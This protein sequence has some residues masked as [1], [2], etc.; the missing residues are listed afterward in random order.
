[1][2]IDEFTPIPKKNK[3]TGIKKIKLNL[4]AQCISYL[5]D[6]E[7]VCVAYKVSKLFWKALAK[8]F[9]WETLVLSQE[10]FAQ[11]ETKCTW[12]EYYFNL[13]KLSK[14]YKEGRPNISFKML[15]CRGHKAPITVLT[16]I[17]FYTEY[18]NVE[19]EIEYNE[20]SKKE[21][22]IT[23]DSDGVIYE[24]FYNKEEKEYQFNQ[25]NKLDK[26][27]KFIKNLRIPKSGQELLIAVGLNGQTKVFDILNNFIVVSKFEPSFTLIQHIA[28]TR[29]FTVLISPQTLS[30]S[31]L[32]KNCMLEEFDILSG[33]LVRQHIPECRYIY[34]NCHRHLRYNK[35][36]C[37]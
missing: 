33:K 15:P 25:I 23:G 20:L 18:N 35:I 17:A 31:H 8:D 13:K 19:D 12:R 32:P 27:V 28:I 6:Y 9:I 11:K 37:C 1:M 3:K 30:H 24:W 14:N 5:N 4:L 7:I 29:E 36:Y 34:N 16:T 26:E 22:I 21:Y 2:E 10:L